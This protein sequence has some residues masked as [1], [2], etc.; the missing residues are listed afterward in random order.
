MRDLIEG[1]FKTLEKLVNGSTG[2]AMLACEIEQS[3][4]VERSGAKYR[5]EGNL[6]VEGKLYRAEG[7]GPTL[8]AAVD[9]VR[10]E[11]VREFKH[12]RG[13]KRGFIK[14]GGAALKRML[15]RDN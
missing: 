3:V 9:R 4:A 11:L 12:A 5:A 10:D 8:E 13:K 2:E 7:E 14:R 1:K 6:S 15:R